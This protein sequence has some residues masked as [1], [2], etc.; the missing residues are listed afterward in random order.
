MLALG[1]LCEWHLRVYAFFKVGRSSDLVAQV[2]SDVLM[3]WCR[4]RIHDLFECSI[5]V[6]LVCLLIVV[7]RSYPLNF[8]LLSCL[9]NHHSQVFVS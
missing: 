8:R 1:W 2:V 6:L 4:L 5:P 3:V 7:L 9:A